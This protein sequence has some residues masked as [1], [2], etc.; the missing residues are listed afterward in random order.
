MAGGCPR[1][2]QGERDRTASCQASDGL[3]GPA[4]VR[5]GDRQ[6]GSGL[7]YRDRLEMPAWVQDDFDP[8]GQLGR[9]T[10]QQDFDRGGKESRRHETFGCVQAASQVV[11]V[12]NLKVPALKVV[13]SPVKSLSWPLAMV[14]L[15]KEMLTAKV[16]PM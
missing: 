8:V 7:V 16:P 12:V 14:S 4:N 2:G 3:E 11:G 9:V 10:E 5:A 15:V 13:I 6:T 1:A